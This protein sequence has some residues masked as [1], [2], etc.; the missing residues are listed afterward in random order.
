MSINEYKDVFENIKC[1]DSFIE[2]MEKILSNIVVTD[3]NNN[4]T[5]IVTK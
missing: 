1:C 3:K 2:K 4:L 5:I